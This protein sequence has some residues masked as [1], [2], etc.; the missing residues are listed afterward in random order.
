MKLKKGKKPGRWTI[1]YFWFALLD[2]FG[3]L[4]EFFPG[5]E[6]GVGLGEAEHL[7]AF[8]GEA[9]EDGK[10]GQGEDVGLFK[11]EGAGVKQFTGEHAVADEHLGF[12]LIFGFA[13]LGIQQSPGGKDFGV[14]AEIVKVEV[15]RMRIGRAGIEKGHVGEFVENEELGKRGHQVHDI[16]GNDKDGAAGAEP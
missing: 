1:L 14:L 9:L 3:I 10:F 8:A 2:G 16:A 7:F 6:N 5:G 12:K 13:E 4:V 15:V 11:R